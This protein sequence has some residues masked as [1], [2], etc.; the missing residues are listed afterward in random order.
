MKLSMIAEN[1]AKIGQ[2]KHRQREEWTGRRQTNRQTKRHRDWQ[3]ERQT[4][5]QAGRQAHTRR[6]EWWGCVGAW[7]CVQR[8]VIVCQSDDVASCWISAT[9]PYDPANNRAV[10]QPLPL[11][12]LLVMAVQWTE[13]SNIA[14]R[15]IVSY[16]HRKFDTHTHTHTGLTALCP[17]LPRRV[18]TRKVKPIWILLKQETVSGS[19]ISWAICKSAPRSRQIAMPAPHHSVF[20]FKFDTPHYSRKS[21]RRQQM[22][23]I[24]INKESDGQGII[25]VTFQGGA[26]HSVERPIGAEC[27]K[28]PYQRSWAT[29]VQPA[30]ACSATLSAYAPA[31]HTLLVLRACTEQF[32]NWLISKNLTLINLKQFL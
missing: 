12:L 24:A 26:V 15:H 32:F 4:T 28:C 21:R 30:N 23:L 13:V 27:E 10:L 9:R 7:V 1:L 18:S 2:G 16:P 22:A 25:S 14:W 20:D 17:G 5:R 3:T 6:A 29:R 31:V 19:G 8:S 11:L